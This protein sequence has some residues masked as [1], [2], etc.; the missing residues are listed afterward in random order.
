[1][2]KV[3]LVVLPFGL[4]LGSG[5]TTALATI[6]ACERGS[7]EPRTESQNRLS[8]NIIP[9]PRELILVNYCSKGVICLS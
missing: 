5:P 9:D 3:G 4:A 6:T 1:V 8:K 7:A 2:V